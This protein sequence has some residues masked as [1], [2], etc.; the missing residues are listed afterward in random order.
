[1]GKLARAE[2]IGN[3]CQTQLTLAWARGAG[4][5]EVAEQARLAG[6]ALAVEGADTVVACA[7]V[8]ARRR[9]A[10]VNVLGA[11]RARPAVDADAAEAADRVRAC[12]AVLAHVRPQA[13]LV[14][15]L[16]AVR[17]RVV[18]RTVAGVVVDAVH[19]T[20][21]V[22]AQMP[23]AVVDVD[24]AV[25][26]GEAG[27]AHAAVRRRLVLG[28]T[29]AGVQARIRFARHVPR[30]AVGA[31]EAL[32][33]RTLVAAA[34]VGAHAVV[35]ARPLGALLGAL[36]DVVDA[37]RTAKAFGTL[38]TIAGA[39]R[40]THG[41]VLARLLR[42][43]VNLVALRAA[44]AVGALTF[45]VFQVVP[46]HALAAVRARPLAR[47]NIR[48][49]ELAQASGEAERALTLERRWRVGLRDYLTGTT[50][51]ATISAMAWI[52]KLTQR[53]G[54]LFGTARL[55]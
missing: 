20:A 42:T 50:V 4:I 12:G 18:G 31:G 25:L 46:Q 28:H 2:H 52:R 53:T 15:V 23:T 21:A 51:E 19:A 38:A 54:K 17:P 24:L 37:V 29:L 34:G 33:A 13:A 27:G 16:R 35:V 45:K 26:A 7:A 32:L 14:H 10:I 48:L 40:A 39:V 49:L 30:L 55:G 22:L 36:I 11:R 5:V 47:A 8:E 43:M 44:P 1:M 41:A 9:R 6:A 3:Q